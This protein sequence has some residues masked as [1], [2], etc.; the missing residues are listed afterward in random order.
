M[1]A[2]EN[3]V[4]YVWQLMSMN[5]QYICSQ[6]KEKKQITIGELLLHGKITQQ[7]SKQSRENSE[8]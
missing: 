8:I 3:W 2:K 1:P 5:I 6:R 7:V 4:C